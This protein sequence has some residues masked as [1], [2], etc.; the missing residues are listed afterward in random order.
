MS[1]HEP[2]NVNSAT[3]N[4]S[5]PATSEKVAKQTKVA[6]DPLTRKL[7]RLGD[8]MKELQQA[9]RKRNEETFG[10]IQGPSMPH[11]R[12]F[13]NAPREEEKRKIL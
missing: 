10:L 12:N 7:K 6:T 4:T 5:I 3:S 1:S 9:P 13:D 8:L 2:K 11:R